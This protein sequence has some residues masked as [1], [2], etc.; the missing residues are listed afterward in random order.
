MEKTNLVTQ[1]E[2]L[3]IIYEKKTHIGYSTIGKQG[4]LKIVSIMNFLQDTASEHA[5]L[6][7]V[8]GFHLAKENL[9]WVIFRYHID[10][11]NHPKW[12]DRVAI[13]TQRFSYKNLYEIRALT[14][15]QAQD[16]CLTKTKK[17]QKCLTNTQAQSK[18][19]AHT[20]NEIVNAKVCWVMINKKNGKPVRLSKFMDKKMLESNQSIK[21]NYLIANSSQIVGSSPNNEGLESYFP[22]I[23]KPET[24]HYQL[25]FKVR[26]HDLDLN[27]HVNN[28]IF[29][30]WGVETVPE[31]IF[32]E[33]SPVTIDVIFNKE[34]LYGDIIISHTE[35][36]EQEGR[37]FTLHSIIRQQDQAELARLNIYWQSLPERVNQF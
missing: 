12:Q 19:L 8:S 17:E 25:P 16:D 36:R 10:I 29:V 24:I 30:E 34:S 31:R 23:I 32:S 26:M 7:G 4:T 28:A 14:I 20:G 2:E 27:G 22:D 6:M 9:A 13:Q 18:C 3:P 33:F 15:T 11:K 35:I 1:Y 21:A 37:L 5:D